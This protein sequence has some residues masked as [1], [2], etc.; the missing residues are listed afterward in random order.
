MPE[1]QPHPIEQPP[2]EEPN[3]L[4]QPSTLP[5]E[6]PPFDRIRL[7]HYRPAF[8][9]G[10]TEQRAEVAAITD[11]DEEPTFANTVE[12]LERSG[13]T[14]G[15]VLAVHDNLASSMATEQRR[16]LDTELA[17]RVAE[18]LDAIRLDPRLFA[19]IDAVHARRADE[20]TAEQRRLVERY[21]QDFVRAGAALPAPDRERLRRLNS[22]LTTLT[23]EFGDR[24]LAEANELAVHVTDR[25]RLEGLADTV[26]ESAAAAA[27]DAGLDGYL[28]PLVLPTIQPAISSLHDRDLRRRLHEAATT[29]GTRG[30][31]HDTREL[32][33]EITRLRAERAALLGFVSHA[34]YVVDEQTAGST[35]AVLGMLHEMVPAAM[36]NLEQERV[37][38]E[39]LMGEDGVEGPLQPWDWAYY[40]QRDL[41]ATY[42][43][44]TDALKPYF[45][46]QRVL[47][48]GIFFAASRLYGLSFRER[49]DLP[50]YAEDVR[51]FEV[52]DGDAPDSRSLGL[53]VCDWFARPTKRGGAWMS[54]FVRQSHLLGTRPVVVVCLNV[55]RPPQGQPALMTLDEV[56]T[57]FHEFGHALHGLFSEVGYPR[58]QGTAVPRDFVEF[59]SQVNEMWA[60]WPEVLARYAVHF[61]TGEP[62]AQDVVDRLV[63]AQAHGQGFDTVSMLGAALLDQEW[64]LRG[65][66][67]PAVAAEDVEELETEAL[68]RHGVLS[69]LV[70][71]RYRS[72][73]FA[74]VFS[75]GYDAAYYS[76]LWSEVLDADIVD[77]FTDEGGL[78]RR[79]GDVFRRELLSVGGTVDPLAA[80]TAVRGRGPRTE[81]LLRRRGLRG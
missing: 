11:G 5:F 40:A 19:R 1:T 24:V 45:E 23:T 56:R 17:P 75:G 55:P 77:W 67:E 25:D 21:H 58:L 43:V 60:W 76:Y 12:A 50:V 69:A 49:D 52:L 72:S 9:A 20:L 81:P 27:T 28:L 71:P 13:R 57:G 62:L 14:L 33:G 26:V 63:A 65:P 18:H 80:F 74:H 46:L 47:H 41:S 48:D 59:P 66:Q 64:H 31:P 2:A 32:V 4:L 15:R 68:A 30:G 37:R 78:S 10:V 7:E 79:T 38:L 51:V 6:H 54:S 39:Q 8:D 29:R 44:D 36:A 16:A 3:P 53:F 70:P 22:R 73:Y 42:D 34:A 35:E 61:E